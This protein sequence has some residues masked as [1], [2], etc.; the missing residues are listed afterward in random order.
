MLLF[1]SKR[2]SELY[3]GQ[4]VRVSSPQGNEGNC[5]Q[6]KLTAMDSE[7]NASTTFPRNPSQRRRSVPIALITFYPATFYGILSVRPPLV[8]VGH[9]NSRWQVADGYQIYANKFRHQ[10]VFQSFKPLHE[11][12][13]TSWLSLPLSFDSLA[14]CKPI[15]SVR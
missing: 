1:E 7:D 6:F 3:N 4:R 9:S 11:M 5:G 12:L 13:S 10:P 15:Q 2:S 8:P 14:G